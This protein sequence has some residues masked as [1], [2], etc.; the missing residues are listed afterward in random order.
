MSTVPGDDAA[1]DAGLLGQEPSTLIEAVEADL[2][3]GSGGPRDP[4]DYQ[5]APPRPD[6]DGTADEAD[7]VEQAAVVPLPAEGPD[8]DAAAGEIED[9][10]IDAPE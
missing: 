7:V 4:E 6:L 8:G 3:G 5:P 2:A 1:R 9:D 10:G